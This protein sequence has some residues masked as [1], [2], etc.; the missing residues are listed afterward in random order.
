MSLPY[1]PSLSAFL[2]GKSVLIFLGWFSFQL[3]LYLLPTGRVVEGLPL[4]SGN[5]LKYRCNGKCICNLWIT[6]YNSKL[7]TMTM[8]MAVRNKYI[9]SRKNV[10]SQ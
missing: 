8:S 3:V 2:D 6:I 1:V 5:Q 4:A 10:P 7:I 9:I